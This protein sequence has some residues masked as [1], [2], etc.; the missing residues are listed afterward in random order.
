MLRQAGAA[1]V[2]LRITSP[3]IRHPCYYGIDMATREQLIAASMS[4]DE[5]AAF[6]GADSLHYLSLGALIEATPHAKSELCRAC[7]D[8]IYPIPVAEEHSALAGLTPEHV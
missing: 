7:F 2:H 5:V 1:E 4:V 3:P 6:V 8:G